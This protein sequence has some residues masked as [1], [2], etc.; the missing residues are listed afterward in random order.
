[1][2]CHRC[3]TGGGTWV[4]SDTLEAIENITRDPG[5]PRELTRRER[6]QV[7]RLL[8]E[9]MTYHLPNYRLPRSLFWLAPEED[10]EDTR[11][12]GA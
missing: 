7:G 12:E 1:M 3:A 11:E 10:R 9:H 8:H 4:A 6:R 5:E 2:R